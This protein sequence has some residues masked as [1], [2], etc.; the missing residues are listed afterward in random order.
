MKGTGRTFLGAVISLMMLGMPTTSNA[1][2][3]WDV[4]P[5][6]IAVLEQGS[7]VVQA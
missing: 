7:T 3:P 5:P 6:G 1:Q 2:N 4:T